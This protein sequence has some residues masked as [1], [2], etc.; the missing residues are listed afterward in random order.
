MDAVDGI[1]EAITRIP[2]SGSLFNHYVD[3]EPTR[4][5]A[6]APQLRRQNL[7][8]YL[9]SFVGKP[10]RDIW[11]AEAPSRYGARWSGVPFTHQENLPDMAKLLTMEADFATPTHSPEIRP[12][13]TSAAIWELLSK[14]MPLLWNT[15]MLHPYKI[16]DG[17]IRNEET[18]KQQWDASRESLKLLLEAARPQ[19]VIAIGAVAAKALQRAGI[20]ALQVAH[21]GRNREKLFWADM[22]KLGVTKTR[23]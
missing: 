21:P 3:L 7:K 13:R 9:R 8:L 17:Q 18:T 4:E 23:P 1:V 6:E 5:S 14:P 10:L 19:R 20:P 2:T 11:I 16:K 22:A 15:V 12:S